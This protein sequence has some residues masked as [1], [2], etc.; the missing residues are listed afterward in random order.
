MCQAPNHSPG[1]II[2]ITSHPAVFYTVMPSP[3]AHFHSP[4]TA[5]THVQAS[6]EDARHLPVKARA[7]SSC[8][9][10]L[11]VAVHSFAGGWV[12]LFFGTTFLNLLAIS[13]C[14]KCNW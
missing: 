8:E 14:A 2:L 7:V 4:C 12:A 10:G 1:S 9:G 11:A 3:H 5:S 13:E 6:G